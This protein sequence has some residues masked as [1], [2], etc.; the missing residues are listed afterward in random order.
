MDEKIAFPACCIAGKGTPDKDGY[1]R[2]TIGKTGQGAKRYSLHRLIYRAY[3]GPIPSG[4]VVRHACDNPCCINPRHLLVGTHKRNMQDMVDRRRHQWGDDHYN[5]KLDA[6]Q[7][8]SI[9]AAAGSH[10]EIASKFGIA[11]STVT[12]IRAKRI[13]KHL[14]D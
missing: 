5:A 1:L 6:D 13:W 9:R 4:H 10:A 2:V 12:N 14:E 3:I 8:R 7:V 11:R